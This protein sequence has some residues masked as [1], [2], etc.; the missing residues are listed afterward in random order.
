[1]KRDD[2]TSLFPDA[3]QEQI[4]KIMSINGNDINKAK[5]DSEAL[6][7]QLAEANT[8]LEALKTAS[9]DGGELAQIKQLAASLKT[10]LDGM[11]AA[12]SLRLMREK[13]AKET[14]V[15]ASLLTGETEEDCTAQANSILEFAKP[16]YP[17]LPD[18]GEVLG[19]P[20]SPATRDKFAAWA[21]ENL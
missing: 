20:K 11:K 18:G 21:K 3:T 1:M 5:G 2:I 10:E 16:K 6:K 15:P 17:N 7:T 19:E 12:E 8:A 4:D 14:K 13:V 9:G